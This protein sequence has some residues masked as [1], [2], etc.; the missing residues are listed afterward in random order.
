MPS[1]GFGHLLRGFRGLGASSGIQTIAAT[2]QQVE[3]YYP[4]SIAYINNN[5]GNLIYIGQAGA[6]PGT[7]MAGTNYTYASFPSYDAGEAALQNQIQLYANQ[8]LTIDQMMA[9]Y[10]PASGAGN[11]P[12]G[13]ASTIASSLGVSPDTT[14]SAAIAG[15]STA[16]DFLADSGNWLETEIS[17]LTDDSGSDLVDSSSTALNPAFVAAGVG[18]LGLLLYQLV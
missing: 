9:K 5:P 8:G 12:T 13:Y 15:G 18:L 1:R 11:D 2:I 4:G 6:S 3:G 7:P 10:A 16:G 17:D 14:V